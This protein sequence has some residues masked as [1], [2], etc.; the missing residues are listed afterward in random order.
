MD[1]DEAYQMY[2][3]AQDEWEAGNTDAFYEYAAQLNEWMHTNGQ[4]ALL[5]YDWYPGDEAMQ[6]DMWNWI[7]TLSHEDREHFFGY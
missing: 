6:E 4:S 2:Y 1:T 7:D 3:E 5:P